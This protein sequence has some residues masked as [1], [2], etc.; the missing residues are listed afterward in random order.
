MSPAAAV[1]A[2][3]HG[4]VRFIPLKYDNSDS[5]RSA[6][7][8]IL[9]LFPHWAEDEAH[10]DFV[11]FTDGITNTLLKAVPSSTFHAFPSVVPPWDHQKSTVLSHRLWRQGSLQPAL[12]FGH[13]GP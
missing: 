2:A 3:E 1:S 8:L 13:Q 9:T 10:I 7:K 11:R 5:Q 4:H 12:A 6:M